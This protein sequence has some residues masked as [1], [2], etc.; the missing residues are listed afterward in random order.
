M[1]PDQVKKFIENMTAKTVRQEIDWKPLAEFPVED[2]GFPDFRN[3]L[4]NTLNCNEFHW[5][6]TKNSF[7]FHHKEGI[8]GLLRIENY[9]GRDSSQSTEYA[10]VVQMSPYDVIHDVTYQCFQDHLA[11]LYMAVL[12]Y[13]NKDISLPD[14]LYKFMSFYD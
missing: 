14:D 9:S 11:V 3:N 10:I 5:L 2:C 8:V 13:L 6:L 12:D 1:M 7:F 4:W